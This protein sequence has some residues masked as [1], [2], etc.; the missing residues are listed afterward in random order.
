MDQVEEGMGIG[1]V[2]SR[3]FFDLLVGIG[4]DAFAGKV[5]DDA[6]LPHLIKNLMHQFK[7]KQHLQLYSTQKN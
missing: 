6:L 5:S 1:I 4:A 3:D 7:L 2:G